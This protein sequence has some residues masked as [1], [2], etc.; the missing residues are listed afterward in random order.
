MSY[1]IAADIGGTKTLIQLIK[2]HDAAHEV[3]KQQHYASAKFKS[4]NDL[5][6]DFIDFEFPVKACCFA[7]AG[8]VKEIKGNRTAQVTNLP[9][10]IDQAKLLKDFKFEHCILINDF[11]ANALAVDSLQEE[12]MIVLQAGHPQKNATRAIIGA[13]TGLGQAVMIPTGNDYKVLS[14]EGGHVNFAP[15]SELEIDLLQYMLK[16]QSPVSYEN[17]LSGSGIQH[18]FDFFLDHL[19]LDP[20]KF[21]HILQ[22]KDPAAAISKEAQNNKQSLSAQT[23]R[24]FCRIYGS[25]TGNLALNCLPWGGLYIA[26]GIAAKNIEYIQSPEFL[27]AFRHKGKMAKLVR[28]FPVILITNPDIGLIGATQTAL[29][30]NDNS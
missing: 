13:G 9:W 1:Y 12:D 30:E 8:P 17:L 10:H 11:E 29:K 21:P 14:T 28:E 27:E 22:A 26:G 23:M 2:K 18:M 20:R 25:Q 24:L 4:F 6:S 19:N 7:I 15:N 5:L 3:V 16:S